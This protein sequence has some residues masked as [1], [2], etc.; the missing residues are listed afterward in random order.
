MDISILESLRGERT[1]AHPNGRGG[2][3]VDSVLTALERGQERYTKDGSLQGFTLPLFA[4]VGTG[5]TP[6]TLVYLYC[7]REWLKEQGDPRWD[8]PVL[9]VVP[10]SVKWNWVKEARKWRKD[11]GIT[12]IYMINGDAQAR[13]A[14]LTFLQLIRPAI[15]VTNYEL[16]AIHQQFLQELGDYDNPF[17]LAVVCDEAHYIKWKD[18]KRSRAV[19]SI[20][21]GFHMAL[22]GTPLSNKPDSLHGVIEW[23]DNTRTFTRTVRGT[24][25]LPNKHCPLQRYD[26]Q[27]YEYHSMGCKACRN[28]SD[29]HCTLSDKP[30]PFNPETP[31]EIIRYRQTGQ[32][33]TFESF[34]DRYCETELVTF[35]KGGREH[36]ARK[37]VGPKKYMMDDLN[38]RLLD[39]GMVRWRRA[40]VLGMN[41]IAYEHISL[42]PTPAQADLYNQL[43]NG[44]INMYGDSGELLDQKQVRSILAQLT[45]F[46]RATTLTPREFQLSLQGRNPEFAPSLKIAVSDSGAKQE[47][48]LEFIADQ[49]DQQD[50][51]DKFLIFSDWT[52]E[53][54][55][56]L[57]RISTRL[58]FDVL[59]DKG[60]KLMPEG[61]VSNPAGYC[62]IIDGSTKH[63]S[64]QQI[65]ERWNSDHDF[66]VFLGSPAAFEGINLQGGLKEVDTAYVVILNMPWLPKDVVQAIGRVLRYGQRGD[67]VALFPA[68][69][70]TIDENMVTTL[71]GKQ[72]AFD[73][74][75]DG[76]NHNM[77]DLFKVNSTRSALKLLG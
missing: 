74:A 48:L 64:R 72:W 67:V 54:R 20:S 60:G 11:L 53:L 5:K 38:Q 66:K 41:T 70:G 32:W 10:A 69:E 34:R 1:T 57:N 30:K 77:A 56:L 62:S 75:I 35:R 43:M 71:L 14:Q 46:R 45:Y 28:W 51:G 6:S 23:L 9:F 24:P 31:P 65:S 7:V 37:I 12:D 61:K 33:G 26:R 2:Y 50:N 21:A 3:Q 22:T 42:E 55:P 59:S 19:R 73:Q 25:P 68:V 13:E 47:W 16:V 8:K 39:F 15:V 44:F 36:Q 49:L 18:S 52:S 27:Q 58:K 63:E 4:D 40:E 29:D 17:F 76:G